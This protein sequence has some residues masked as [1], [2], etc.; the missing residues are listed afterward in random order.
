[1]NQRII[2][3]IEV[4]N[5]D[6]I[7]ELVLR[8]I[9]EESESIGLILQLNLSFIANA[10]LI[11]VVV[12]KEGGGVEIKLPI[13]RKGWWRL[14]WKFWQKIVEARF[15]KMYNNMYFCLP[16]RLI[17]ER[18]TLNQIF[19]FVIN[20]PKLVKNL[21]SMI[22]FLIAFRHSTRALHSKIRAK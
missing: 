13:Q 5:L 9:I 14:L 15:N 6:L 12:E 18:N 19:N 4:R 1:M 16:K 11:M 7:N 22:F 3:E 17:R 2:S 21:W 10:K 20:K 8:L